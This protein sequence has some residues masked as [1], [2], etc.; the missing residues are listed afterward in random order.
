MPIFNDVKGAV[1]ELV[2]LEVIAKN[3]PKIN[4]IFLGFEEAVGVFD[5]DLIAAERKRFQES[6][7]AEEAMRPYSLEEVFDMVEDYFL[8]VYEIQKVKHQLMSINGKTPTFDSPENT[9]LISSAT[10]LSK[11][12]DS[13]NPNTEIVYSYADLEGWTQFE[14]TVVLEGSFGAAGLQDI[15]SAVN[16]DIIDEPAFVPGQV[17]LPDLQAQAF[18]EHETSWGDDDTVLHTLV[19]VRRTAFNHRSRITTNFSKSAAASFAHSR[20]CS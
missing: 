18:R 8:A 17:G 13:L 20:V 14:K 9:A 2:R 6:G 16:Y 12:L 1:R 3:N 10:L 5:K 19:S 4:H 11:M 7:E 15:Y